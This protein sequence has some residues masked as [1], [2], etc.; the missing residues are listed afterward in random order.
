MKARWAFRAE[1]GPSPQARRWHGAAVTDEVVSRTK[2]VWFNILRIRN[3]H[4]GRLPPL[5]IGRGV[6]GL[7]RGFFC[8]REFLAAWRPPLRIGRRVDGLGRGVFRIRGVY[9]GRLPPLR[10]GRR[11]DGLGRG[12]FRIRGFYGGL[13][14]A[15][16]AVEAAFVSVSGGVCAAKAFPRLTSDHTNTK[17]SRNPFRP[18]CAGR[19]CLACRRFFRR[20]RGPPRCPLST[21]GSFSFCP[22]P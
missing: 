22:A 9:G 20:R 15:A 7:G 19:S 3:A 12:F 18:S 14:A 13:E 10:I 16:T 6:V 4:G 2:T 5:R 8:I 11:V 1:P 21:K 17:R